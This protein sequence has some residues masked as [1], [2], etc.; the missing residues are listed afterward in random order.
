MLTSE[1]GAQ[2]GGAGTAFAVLFPKRPGETEHSLLESGV[3]TAKV[4]ES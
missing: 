2:R 1:L 4:D 3:T